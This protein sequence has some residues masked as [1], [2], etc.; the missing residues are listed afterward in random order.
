M[1]GDQS[2]L[3]VPR[4]YI[5]SFFLAKNTSKWLLFNLFLFLDFLGPSK[6]ELCVPRTTILAGIFLPFRH[7]TTQ[8]LFWLRRQDKTPNKHLGFRN[9]V[10]MPKTEKGL[11]PFYQIR[12]GTKPFLIPTKL[13]SK[14]TA[15]FCRNGIQ[16]ARPTTTP[17][18]PGPGHTQTPADAQRPNTSQ[19][20][21]SDKI[22]FFQ[23][24]V[25]G[26]YL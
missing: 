21:R 16:A 8:K 26:D 7:P 20:D 3:S 6:P 19:F 12:S 14:G 24:R 1:T 2:E 25:A 17:R 13:Y 22:F 4:T 9:F 5:F 15:R 11:F 18:P 23:N 10:G